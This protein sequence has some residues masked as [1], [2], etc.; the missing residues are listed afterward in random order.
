[1][2]DAS[3][4][5]ASCCGPKD[6]DNEGKLPEVLSTGSYKGVTISAQS[7]HLTKVPADIIGKPITLAVH[8]NLTLSLVNPTTGNLD[9]STEI[10]KKIALKGGE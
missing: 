9:H 1:M 2:N 4:L 7:Y 8:P 10:A 3:Y 5:I 6:D